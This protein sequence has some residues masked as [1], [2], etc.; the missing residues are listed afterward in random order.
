MVCRNLCCQ[1]FLLGTE[2]WLKRESNFNKFKKN[3]PMTWMFHIM[4]Q[5]LI[6]ATVR[7]ILPY[8]FLKML[9]FKA[10]YSSYFKQSTR[11]FFSTATESATSLHQSIRVLQWNMTDRIVLCVITKLHLAKWVNL[12]FLSAQNGQN[13]F[14]TVLCSFNMNWVMFQ[15][16]KSQLVPNRATPNRAMSNG[17]KKSV[18]DYPCRPGLTK[19]H[20]RGSAVEFQYGHP[21]A[22]D[23]VFKWALCF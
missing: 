7:T 13:L 17:L 5:R 11:L 20:L 1:H 19:I 14:Q 15:S 9:I 4:N 3:N 6:P 18:F 16:N 10:T 22:I 8:L 12:S 21:P 23:P 2:Q